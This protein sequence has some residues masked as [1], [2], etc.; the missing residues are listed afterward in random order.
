MTS[1]SGFSFVHNALQGGYPI[2]EAIRAV[3]PYTDEVVVVD[4]A[5]TDGTRDLLQRLGVRIVDG[6]WGNQAG[7]T[8]KAAH[9]LHYH[10][11]GD[12]IIHFEADEVYDDRL[13]RRIRGEITQGMTDLAVYR[14]QLEQNFQRCR[15]YPEPVHRIFPR[16]LPVS[17]VKAGHTTNRHDAAYVIPAE[18]G[19]LWDITNCF[20]DNWFRRIEQQAQLWNKEPKYRMVPLHFLHEAEIDRQQAGF[21]LNDSHWTWKTT[22]FDIPAILKPLVGMVEYAS[23]V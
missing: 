4:M 14:L 13:L 5:S 21:R 16:S 11:Q 20:R 22:P 1:V 2:A 15:W 8:L 3:Q 10:C 23:T 17:T 9:A 12:V 7:E 6:E 18:A 19:F